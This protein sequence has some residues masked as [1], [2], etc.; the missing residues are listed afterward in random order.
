MGKGGETFVLNMGK[1][2]RI[3]TLAEDLIRLS[4]LEP[5]KDIE[6]TFTGIRPGE[7]LSEA[8]WYE[9][10]EYQPTA[11]P[12]IVTLV[13]EESLV[14]K[15]LEQA[16][17]NLTRLAAEGGSEGIINLFDQ[18]IP[19]CSLGGQAKLDVISVV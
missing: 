15:T 16:I 3:L 11:H 17:E 19:G 4:G 7:K 18:S 14:G 12:D 10:A 9:G 13:G 6:I 1:Q 8:L 5:G 2:I